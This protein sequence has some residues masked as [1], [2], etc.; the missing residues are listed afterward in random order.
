LIRQVF[1]VTVPDDLVRALSDAAPENVSAHFF[2][3]GGLP[4]SAR[5]ASTVADGRIQIE[6]DAG[7]RVAP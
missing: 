7:F 5:W 6:S 1:A 4:A 2:S 3:F